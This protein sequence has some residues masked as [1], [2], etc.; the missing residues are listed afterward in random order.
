VGLSVGFVVGFR[1][2]NLVDGFLVDGRTD[3]GVLVVGLDVGLWLV[4]GD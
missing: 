3:V 4:E 2:G 1:D